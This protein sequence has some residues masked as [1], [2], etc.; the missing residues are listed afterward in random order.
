MIENENTLIEDDLTKECLMCGFEF[1]PDESG[2]ECCDN[3]CA[4]AYYGWD[5]EYWDDEYW[6]EDGYEDAGYEYY[7]T[8]WV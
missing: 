6:D 4:A 7:G 8:D 5:D 1:I 3:G 2:Q